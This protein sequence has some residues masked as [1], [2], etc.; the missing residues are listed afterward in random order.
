MEIRIQQDILDNNLSAYKIIYRDPDED[1]F[2]NS[3]RTLTDFELLSNI[4]E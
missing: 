4:L 3:I 1:V 2:K